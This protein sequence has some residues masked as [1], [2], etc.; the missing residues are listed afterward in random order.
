MIMKNLLPLLAFLTLAIA[1]GGGGG[2]STAPE[3][4]SA[5][6]GGNALGNSKVEGVYDI[7]IMSSNGVS[8]ST[9]ITNLRTGSSNVYTTSSFS[10]TFEADDYSVYSVVSGNTGVLASVLSDDLEFYASLT[11]FKSVVGDF[12]NEKNTAG[13]NNYINF[14]E[15]SS[16]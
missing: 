8:Y 5:T 9:N 3:S 13:N 12:L 10:H 16:T 2:D 6:L 14:N 15:D 4:V 1:C 7:S 11:S